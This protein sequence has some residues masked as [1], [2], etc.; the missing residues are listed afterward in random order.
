[1]R[2]TIIKAGAMLIAALAVAVPAGLVAAYLVGF[3]D[4]VSVVVEGLGYLVRWGVWVVMI[5]VGWLELVGWREVLERPVELGWVWGA[6]AVIL[7]L[8]IEAEVLAHGSPPLQKVGAMNVGVAVV[9][10][11]VCASW[12]AGRPVAHTRK[13]LE[14]VLMPN[15]PT[16]TTTWGPESHYR[17]P[18]F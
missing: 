4:P 5:F 7:S 6:L 12:L 15:Q 8:G 14:G 9:L 13:R 18:S 11:L 1:M 2:S 10:V 16:W 17:Y 3:A